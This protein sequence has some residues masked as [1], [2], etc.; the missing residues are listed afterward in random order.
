MLPDLYALAF[1]ASLVTGSSFLLATDL[2]RTRGYFRV[3]RAIRFPALAVTAMLGATALVLWMAKTHP[4]V[5]AVHD[6]LGRG[7][8]G[9]LPPLAMCLLY[10]VTPEPGQARALGG[11]KAARFLRWPLLVSA[12]CSGLGYLVLWP[13]A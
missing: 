5:T 1:L 13:F 10:S 12:T 11:W 4:S 9:L 2:Q 8:V 6:A 7:A 3:V